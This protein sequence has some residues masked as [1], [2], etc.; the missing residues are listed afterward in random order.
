M[1][2]ISVLIKI[3]ENIISNDRNRL[4][5]ISEFQRIIWNS[6]FKCSELQEE[7]LG[8]LALDLDYYEPNPIWRAEDPSYYGEKRLFE[9]INSALEGLNKL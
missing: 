4:E 5:K 9:E 2:D 8:D 3:L 7:I 6:D 1:K